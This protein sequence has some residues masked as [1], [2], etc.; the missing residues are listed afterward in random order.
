M[1][2]QIE[3]F[4]CHDTHNVLVNVKI[5][6]INLLYDFFNA[7]L[8]GNVFM[9]KIVIVHVYVNIIFTVILDFIVKKNKIIFV[10]NL[11]EMRTYLL[12]VKLNDLCRIF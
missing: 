8:T 11:L 6:H 7:R 5:I 4:T 1:G 2:K 9:K 12:T 3:T 10:V